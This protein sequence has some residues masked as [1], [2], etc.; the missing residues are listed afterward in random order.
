MQALASSIHSFMA[1]VGRGAVEIYNE[2]SLQHELGIYLHATLPPLWKAQFE[3]PVNFFNLRRCDFVKK[4]I[5]IACF[6]PDLRTKYM[7]ELKYP[8]N[9]QVPEQMFKA[10]EDVMFV[11]QMVANGFGASYFV[12]VVEDP[13]FCDG[14]ERDGIYRYFRGGEPITGVIQKPT[15]AKDQT[16]K[17]TGK[18]IIRW[19]PLTGSTKYAL[20]EIT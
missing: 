18:H 19:Q 12:M 4:E 13:L 6:T 14:K 3:R 9:G 7:I 17:I 10:C 5:D 11:E 2:F 1:E 15:G 16:V 8:R 20:V